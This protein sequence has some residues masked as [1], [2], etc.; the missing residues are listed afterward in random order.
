MR[1]PLFATLCRLIKR[2]A[3]DVVADSELTLLEFAKVLQQWARLGPHTLHYIPTISALADVFT[4]CQAASDALERVLV[5]ISPSDQHDTSLT[6]PA[7]I[8]TISA[9][10]G[11]PVGQVRALLSTF[12]AINE[13]RNAPFRIHDDVK[14]SYL[15]GFSMN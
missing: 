6:S 12:S 8:E 4:D 11:V 3:G 2:W 7:R 13:I 1:N 15:T 9:A 10:S 14:P 5:H